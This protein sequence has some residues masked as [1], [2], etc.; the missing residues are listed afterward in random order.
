MTLVLNVITVLN[1]KKVKK[2]THNIF[3]V[4]DKKSQLTNFFVNR[5][6]LF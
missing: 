5:C 4:E 6:D 2:E 3:K 1:I